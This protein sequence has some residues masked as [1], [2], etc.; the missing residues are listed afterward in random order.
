[1]LCS[2][3]LN[4]TGGFKMG[5]I[6]LGS[7]APSAVTKASELWCAP[8]PCRERARG[9]PACSRDITILRASA[10]ASTQVCGMATCGSV[11]T[12]KGI[13]A[14]P[15]ALQP[16][17]KLSTFRGYRCLSAWAKQ[18]I[19]P[20][21]SFL[22]TAMPFWLG[23]HKKSSPQGRHLAHIFTP[24]PKILLG[25]KKRSQLLLPAPAVSRGGPL[26]C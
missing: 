25:S 16:S 24:T 23:L 5:E 22:E 17:Q 2:W 11:G 6:P 12:C 15:H 10:G 7:G 9:Q 20:L 18:C 4:S 1:M 3:V 14:V 21:I 8:A 26:C 19:P 13:H